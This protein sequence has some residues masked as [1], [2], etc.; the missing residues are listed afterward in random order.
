MFALGTGLLVFQ[1][2]DFATLGNYQSSVTQLLSIIL[3]V[4]VILFHFRILFQTVVLSANSISRE[5]QSG[6]WDLL[7]LTGLDAQILIR[8]K[9]AATIRQQ[10]RRYLRL[11]VL[12]GV[13]VSILGVSIIASNWYFQQDMR[14]GIWYPL[15]MT[16]L[17]ITFMIG[18]TLLNLLL[19]TAFGVYA[20]VRHTRPGTALGYSL[21]WRLLTLGGTAGV[22]MGLFFLLLNWSFA[23]GNDTEL[24][25]YLPALGFT[26]LDNGG[27]A[28]VGLVGF[29]WVDMLRGQDMGST[30][31][32]LLLGMASGVLTA[33][34]L[35][36]WWTRRLLR[37]AS[38]RLMLNG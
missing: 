31:F 34:G 5:K 20:G 3:I 19:T 1:F 11:G 13:A 37:S 27:L 22:F 36:I 18:I 21:G 38:R 30:N 6:N 7:I 17:G 12:R 28:G 35:S 9:W 32:S 29:P 24:L 15:L 25:S 16:V 33:I 23:L 10:W 8:S 4:L 2:W 14:P 26:L